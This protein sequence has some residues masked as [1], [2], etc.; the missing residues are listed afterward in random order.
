M[1]YKGMVGS[2][3]SLPSP[4]T[5]ALVNDFVSGNPMTDG[6]GA[7]YQYHTLGNFIDV[8]TNTI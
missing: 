2:G 6:T 3:S 8:D 7:L 5:E 1:G 4:A